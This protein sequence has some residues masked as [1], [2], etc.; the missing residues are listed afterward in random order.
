LLIPEPLPPPAPTPDPGVTWR[1]RGWQHDRSLVRSAL[2]SARVPAGR[3]ARFDCCGQHAWVLRSDAAGGKYRIAASY[4]RDRFCKP[5]SA[6]RA[7]SL[8][9]ALRAELADHPHRFCTLTLRSNGQPLAAEIDRLLAAFRELRR[10]RWWSDRVRGGAG[11][12][13]VT[14]SAGTRSWHPHLHLILDSAWM[15]QGELSAEWHHVTRDS[16]I[17]DV[18]LVRDRGAV[19]N[20][21][22]KYAAKPLSSSFLNRPNQLPEAIGA[23][24]GRRAPPARMRRRSGGI[25]DVIRAPAARCKGQAGVLRIRRVS[26]AARA[27]AGRS[28][29][30]AGP[31]RCRSN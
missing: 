11:F 26:L 29:R 6:A 30:S 23:M 12:L 8:A 18:R 13:E 7:A 21:V 28:A 20:Y 17:V 4:C 19:A 2:A 1:H 24:A 5:C 22:V 14:Y 16:Y 10:R 31:P 15:S 3:L 25:A 27:C 9:A